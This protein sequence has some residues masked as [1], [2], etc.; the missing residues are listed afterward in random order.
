MREKKRE[1]HQQQEILLSSIGS[2]G[3]MVVGVLLLLLAISGCK[4]K[5]EDPTSEVTVT[6]DKVA[7]AEDDGNTFLGE[8]VDDEKQEVT[9]T[10]I[11]RE[12]DPLGSFR[13][14][15]A[16]EE[17]VETFWDFPDW[18]QGDEI[19]GGQS[20]FISPFGQV[21]VYESFQYHDHDTVS[22]TY[23]NDLLKP[24]D[25]K[26]YGP[27]W[28]MIY[29]IPNGIEK[30]D[31]AKLYK[32]FVN[33]AIDQGAHMTANLAYGALAVF[34]DTTGKDIW[35]L[36]EDGNYNV[37]ITVVEEVQLRPG[38]TMTI[39]AESFI[40]DEMFF[41]STLSDDTFYTLVVTIEGGDFSLDMDKRDRV[42]GYS[43]NY[44][45]SMLMDREKGT[46]Y[47]FDNLPTDEGVLYYEVNT[48]GEGTGTIEFKLIETAK[49]TEITMDDALGA[50]V[51]EAKYVDQVHLEPVNEVYVS[52][53]TFD[54]DSNYMDKTAEGDYIITVP[55]GD[56]KATVMPKGKTSVSNYATTLIPVYPNKITKVSIPL[57]ME[58]AL[59]KELSSFALTSGIHI[60]RTIDGKDQI[61][62]DFT[63]ADMETKTIA[64]DL[65]NTN[66]MEGGKEVEILSIENVKTPPSVVLVLD[67]S[68]SMKGQLD[69]TLVTAKA[70]IEGLPEDTDIQ[71][72]DFDTTP[73][74][75][76]GHSKSQ[77]ID[78]LSKVTVGGATA[79]YDSIV[80]AT[81]LLED[82]ERPTIVAFSDG[83][84]ENY[85]GSAPGSKL[86]I[87]EAMS[88]VL[89][90]GISVFTIGFGPNHDS[91]TL[92]RIA[93]ESLGQYFAAEDQTA[94]G[95]VFEAIKNKLNSSYTATYKRPTQSNIGDIPVVTL[96]LD[97]S[98][99]M[100]MAP[101]DACG[102]RMDNVK[103]LFHDFIMA[104][105]NQTQMQLMTFNNEVM[106]NQG[107]TTDKTRMLSA[108]G[109]L[110]AGGGTN[111]L[112]SVEAGYKTLEVIP[113]S[114]KVMI[115][116]TDAALDV[117]G[118]DKE[119]YDKLLAD[120]KDAQINVLWVGLG[121]TPNP[122]DFEHAALAT[123]GDFVISEDAA[124][125]KAATD[126]LMRKVATSDESIKT[127][128]AI[129]VV[130]KD[131]MGKLT[132]Y[133]TS[134]LAT[135]SPLPLSDEV[136]VS[137]AINYEVI[138]N[139]EQYDSTSSTYLSGDQVPNEAI[140][141]QKRFEVDETGHN[142][143][144]TLKVNEI[145][146]LKQLDGVSAPRGQRFVALLVEAA[147]TMP[148][149]EVVVYP[150]GSGHPSSWLTDGGTQGVVQK[151]KVPYM[152]PDI[153]A[154]FALRFNDKATHGLSPATWL[155]SQPLSVPGI[156]S[157]VI[158]PD[159]SVS[160]ALIFLVPDEAM[161]Q[162]SL[163]YYDTNYG[164]ID[165]PIV[166]EMSLEDLNIQAL[167]TQL[168]GAMKDGFQV[169]VTGME[170]VQSISEEVLAAEH[171]LFRIFEGDFMTQVQARLNLDPLER[172]FLQLP[173][174]AG[175]FYIPLSEATSLVPYG[176]ATNTMVAPGSKN[177][178]RWV[179]EV[180][181]GL[182]NNEMN[183]MVELVDEDL[184]IPAVKGNYLEGDTQDVYHHEYADISVNGLYYQQI[185]IGG[186]IDD[187]VVAD[188]TITDVKDGYA[189]RG[190][191]PTLVL[192]EDG[193]SL[194]EAEGEDPHIVNS[195][196]TASLGN[197]SSGNY[198]GNH[199]VYPDNVTGALILGLGSESVIYDGTSRR[200]YIVY[201]LES[202][203]VGKT[204]HLMSKTY[205]DLKVTV[206]SGWIPEENLAV[207][208]QLPHDVNFEE[209]MVEAIDKA[210]STYQLANPQKVSEAENQALQ[211]D[212]S[213]STEDKVTVTMPKISSYGEYVL[214]DIASLE[215][216][217]YEIQRLKIL[218]KDYGSNPFD[219]DH[220]AQSVLT[221]GWATIPDTINLA[222]K[223][224]SKL[225]Y[226][227]TLEKVTVT[228]HGRSILDT[229][230]NLSE[231][232]FD[233]PYLPA[234]SFL[235]G[236]GKEVIWVLPFAIPIKEAKGLG[237]LADYEEEELR[238]E[239]E[240]LRIEYLVKDTNRDRNDAVNDINN[241]LGG[242]E[243][244]S[245]EPYWV[246]VLDQRLSNEQLSL[247]CID[248]G[249]F[250]NGTQMTAYTDG[251]LGRYIGHQYVDIDE[252]EVLEIKVTVTGYENRTYTK[253][254]TDQ[255]SADQVFMTLGH[256]LPIPEA[257]SANY[258]ETVARTIY[259]SAAKPDEMSALKWRAHGLI[260]E[261][262]TQ[263]GS[264]EKEMSSAYQMTVGHVEED[265][266]ILI[267][268]TLDDDRI[269][270]C[271]MDLLNH[272]QEIMIDQF[273]E[274]DD[275]DEKMSSYRI[276]SGI[277]A[278]IL[279]E[280]LLGD[281]GDGVL[282]I[283]AKRPEG[284]DLL[285]LE[286]YSDVVTKEAL[287]QQGY[288][289]T[290]AQYLLECR[291]YIIIPEEPSILEDGQPHYGWLEFD[292]DYR[293]I[294]LLDSYEHG[295]MSS[296]TIIQAEVDAAYF[297]VG[298]FTGIDASLWSVSAFSL[299]L[300]DYEA[301]KEA[302][303]QFA[304]G[305]A[306]NFEVSNGPFSMG[307]G[308]TPE[309]SQSLGPI[310]GSL[311]SG[312]GSLSE[313]ILGFKNGYE[314]GVNYY[315]SKMP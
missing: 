73:K 112:D 248:I 196:I 40:D 89:A 12:G 262:L 173:T 54:M 59:D 167:P 311:D 232:T 90:S 291:N 1:A 109:S 117:S 162:L 122:E 202:G 145:I 36:L 55:A 42:N 199:I 119:K 285:I 156:S 242:G 78:N 214:N 189:T 9:V 280:Q 120:I 302:A 144:M 239:Y 234:V 251:V 271:H 16:Q 185:K 296:E 244:N 310:K 124:V 21:S 135:L 195:A 273:S 139:L 155:A 175:D 264:F 260:A 56:W 125:L 33:R 95:V 15:L 165:L 241:A 212:L 106:L 29:P 69:D 39:E 136:I 67:S 146:F 147:N 3:L 143:A 217:Q 298:A 184:V 129:S 38:E 299:Q 231:D 301:I 187:Y 216:L 305:L 188:V 158:E 261:Y 52:H 92:K 312:G 126:K 211:T 71:V 140:N 268:Q 45:E 154:H 86:T 82:L 276:M 96:V 294:G 134:T 252:Q 152:I 253:V 297:L 43:R 157:I 17:V 25:R 193:F 7:P 74:L 238:Y 57:S 85:N 258:L 284:A 75:L 116:L 159:E 274:V 91:A 308:G 288:P 230:M 250:I 104:L 210:V 171:S 207:F 149:Q 19:V 240:Y 49:S 182:K 303:K 314:S 256:N 176:M 87:D 61:S 160:G 269:Y 309:L 194:D 11:I 228:D 88:Q 245:D 221:Q 179:F 254:L 60:D 68:G 164:H 181:E 236:E 259:E 151:A 72:M 131:A 292:Q 286:P 209:A 77:A 2:Y 34:R 99:S 64:P 177:L 166:G 70:F 219:V 53:E 237:Y 81:K 100:D 172:F 84:D 118:D 249:S 265:M 137:E 148:T 114:Q 281:L 58:M 79:L 150:D 222:V 62:F 204:Y 278:T 111:I 304:M 28:E 93:Q 142:E 94:L 101:D 266:S 8:T 287:I 83:A 315:F 255:L 174:G 300:S 225:G 213:D 5:V 277:H 127:S 115:Y 37:K 208:S 226:I 121:E 41:T 270:Q 108:L 306:D 313:D 133:S 201:E 275:W 13:N 161:T 229:Y 295:A 27:S 186:Y 26:V 200:G 170:D 263:Q 141:I 98:G 48:R 197:F 66:I 44:S 46:T 138:G 6:T 132:P 80:E 243:S 4:S 205:E 107:M 233:M 283:W 224:L 65:E 128:I 22:F 257:E 110:Q 282:G 23:Y 235:D 180:P 206:T 272:Q 24:V 20:L 191:A 279:E 130:K 183:L 267:I 290:L 215:D 223:G 169:T 227:T 105:P 14:L 32:D 168:E 123:A 293:T 289:E 10:S 178:A 190:I 103:S 31:E 247:D 192:V 163:H 50:I 113:S 30:D 35:V 63:L 218:H 18:I 76:E 198:G 153:F 246:E 203:N 307:I 97:V 51:F 47:Y 102:Y 220:S